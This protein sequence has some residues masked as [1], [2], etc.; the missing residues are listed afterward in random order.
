MTFEEYFQLAGCSELEKSI[1]FLVGFAP[2]LQHRHYLV[3]KSRVSLK[4]RRGPSTGLAC[5]L[6]HG[7]CVWAKAGQDPAEAWKSSNLPRRMRSN[8][9]PLSQQAWPIP[10]RPGGHRLPLNPLGHHTIAKRQR[11]TDSPSAV[12][13]LSESTGL[14]RVGRFL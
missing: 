13:P 8:S 4:D 12:S 3:D 14:F 1:R 11:G 10:W 6:W 9:T 5:Q 7:H 2:S